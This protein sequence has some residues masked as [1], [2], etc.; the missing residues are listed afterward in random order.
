L[1]LREAKNVR[2]LRNEDRSDL[3]RSPAV[4]FIV[5]IKSG[6]LCWAEHVT[7]MGW[8]EICTG[9]WRGNF[10]KFKKE[11]GGQHQDGDGICGW[12]RE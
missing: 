1:D 10:W 6:L 2:I 8:Q 4:V 3:Q 5:D 9:F 11:T 12:G 7:Q